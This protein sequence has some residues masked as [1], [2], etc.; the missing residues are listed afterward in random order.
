MKQI[1]IAL[2]IVVACTTSLFAQSKKDSIA[3]R[4][5]E[6]ANMKFF[7]PMHPKQ[8]AEGHAKCPICKM[9]MVPMKKSKLKDS[10]TK[11]QMH[12]MKM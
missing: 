3:K 9:D 6:M 11:K 4:N 7:C 10:A 12:D 1:L 2:V 8:M 5:M